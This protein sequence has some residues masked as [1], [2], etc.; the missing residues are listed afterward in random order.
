MCRV[1]YC[2]VIPVTRASPTVT[3][4]R[5]PSVEAPNR[6]GKKK[7]LPAC[8]CDIP[9][10]NFLAPARVRTIKQGR[11]LQPP[12]KLPHSAPSLLLPRASSSSFRPPHVAAPSARLP[13]AAAPR[14]DVVAPAGVV[15]VSRSTRAPQ[16]HLLLGASH[17]RLPA[18]PRHVRHAGVSHTRV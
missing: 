12:Q 9:H 16:R 17:R 13:R 3:L 14:W 4:S 6:C 2:I 1:R 18:Y 10:R 8:Y 7:N 11:A 15:G 5:A